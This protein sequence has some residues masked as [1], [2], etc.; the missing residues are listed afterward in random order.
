MTRPSLETMY[1]EMAALAA[2]THWSIDAVLD[3]EHGERR[4]WLALLGHVAAET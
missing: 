1:S 4:R 3:L 2:A